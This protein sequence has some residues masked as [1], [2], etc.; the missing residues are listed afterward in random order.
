M[1]SILV[2]AKHNP[3]EALRVAAGL[4]LLHSELRVLGIGAW[5]D[6]AAVREQHELVEFIEIPCEALTDPAEVPARVAAAVAQADV[7][8]QL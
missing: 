1:K 2:I 3:A 8:Y 7:V 6:T 4:S 5:P